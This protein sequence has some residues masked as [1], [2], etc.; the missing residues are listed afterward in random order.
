MNL[1][2]DEIRHLVS[3][4]RGKFETERY[5]FAPALKVLAKVDPKPKLEPLPPRKE[6][7]PSLLMQKKGRRR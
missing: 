5:P 2:D 7:I 3:Y 6:Y 4:A 1:T